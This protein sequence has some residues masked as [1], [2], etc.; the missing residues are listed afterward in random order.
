MVRS[1]EIII[2]LIPLCVVELCRCGVKRKLLIDDSISFKNVSPG[3]LKETDFKSC[4]SRPGVWNTELSSQMLVSLNLSPAPPLS[5]HIRP[6]WCWDYKGRKKLFTLTL[7]V[8]GSPLWVRTKSWWKEVDRCY[9]FCSFCGLQMS[10]LKSLDVDSD[11]N[12]FL[13]FVNCDGTT[14]IVYSFHIS[15]EDKNCCWTGKQHLR[16]QSSGWLFPMAAADWWDV[17]STSVASFWL[18][19][20]KVTHTDVLS[21][22]IVLVT[23]H[24][25]I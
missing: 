21:A 11:F 8:S 13:F 6:F 1:G 10:V 18:Q 14:A 20:V 15:K 19:D 23:Y 24:W 12:F 2:V 7:F 16:S 3:D 4:R 5:A 9:F 25:N 17:L 22:R